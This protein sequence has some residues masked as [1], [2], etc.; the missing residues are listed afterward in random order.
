MRFWDG[1]SQ[2]LRRWELDRDRTD[3]WDREED[4][5]DGYEVGY[6]KPPRH[7]QFQK[8]RSGNPRGRPRSSKSVTTILKKAL[9]EPVIATVNGRKRKLSKYEALIIRF[10]NKAVE[11]DHRAVQYLLAKMPS[12][13]KE[14][15]EISEPGGLSKE[16][17]DHIR[18]IL[19][20]QDDEDDE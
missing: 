18:R 16:A 12:I 8:G 5:D 10:V 6:C 20:G 14:F 17:G 9:L 7:T 2:R 15:R 19:L 13:G 1:H 4:Q 11:G 3:L